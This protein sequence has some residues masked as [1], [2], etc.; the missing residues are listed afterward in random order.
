MAAR[1]FLNPYL[2]IML[3]LAGMIVMGYFLYTP[4]EDWATYD[5]LTIARALVFLG[6]TYLL[7]QTL[8]EL[9]RN[10]TR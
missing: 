1:N 5:H 4:F 8:R 6:F 2:K 10:P 9:L 3:C 7:V